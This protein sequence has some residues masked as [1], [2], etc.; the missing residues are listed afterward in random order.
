MSSYFDDE[1]DKSL[2]DSMILVK[3]RNSGIERILKKYDINSRNRQ[4]KDLK[5]LTLIKSDESFDSKKFRNR[6]SSYDQMSQDSNSNEKRYFKIQ[7]E[8]M[9]QSKC[10]HNLLFPSFDK[11]YIRI[12]VN[13]IE[14]FNLMYVYKPPLIESFFK[15]I[16][17]MYYS[18]KEIFSK[19]LGHLVKIIIS[20]NLKQDIVGF[21]RIESINNNI[22]CGLFLEKS[23]GYVG[24][25]SKSGNIGLQNLKKNPFFIANHFIEIN[26]ILW[27]ETLRKFFIR[28]IRDYIKYIKKNKNDLLVK[29]EQQEEKEVIFIKEFLEKKQPPFEFSNGGEKKHYQS[30]SLDFLNF[31]IS[32]KIII[33][34]CRELMK[35]GE[36][37]LKIVFQ[38][39]KYPNYY[40]ELKRA[41]SLL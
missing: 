22:F 31:I 8:V 19:L 40:L 34:I 28:R 14:R 35:E 21:F 27:N 41:L 6:N 25:L 32:K 30:H 26:K 9:E 17:S 18:Y 16:F 36:D 37:Y 20:S 4:N 15:S 29:F 11:C 39:K 12:L 3:K 38:F 5:N 10:V 7:D 23:H 33:L 13:N 24:I 1:T 2:D